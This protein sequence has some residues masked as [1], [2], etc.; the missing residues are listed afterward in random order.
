MSEKSFSQLKF[1]WTGSI[2]AEN[3]KIIVK[4]H[5]Q[6]EKHFEK[7]SGTIS[8]CSPNVTQLNKEEK[9]ETQKYSYHQVSLFKRYDTEMW[10]K[11]VILNAA[12]QSPDH[13]TLN[14]TSLS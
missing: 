8:K 7:L 11:S 3:L 4:T 6:N 14:G 1:K 2:L 9:W 13:T 5:P 12:D 10:E